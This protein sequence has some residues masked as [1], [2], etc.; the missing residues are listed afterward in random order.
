[1]IE[2]AFFKWYCTCLRSS[3][4]EYSEKSVDTSESN[5]CNDLIGKTKGN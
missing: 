4:E 1:M 2:S 5:C 3:G